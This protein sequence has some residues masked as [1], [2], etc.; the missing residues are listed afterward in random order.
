MRQVPPW[1]L[2]RH[3]SQQLRPAVDNRNVPGSNRLLCSFQL[4]RA[5]ANLAVSGI[6]SGGRP[7][8][9]SNRPLKLKKE[10]RAVISQIARS[11]QPDSL[12]KTISS[13]PTR[14]GVSVSLLA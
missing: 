6:W 2:V 11:F 1:Y 3:A 10:A 12:K 8:A 4:S 13:S 7:D 14:L 9:A 5:S